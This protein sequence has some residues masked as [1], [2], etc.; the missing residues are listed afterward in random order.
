MGLF[1]FFKKPVK[2]Q[3][4]FF[5]SL[6][7]LAIKGFTKSIFKGQ[8]YFAPTQHII[9][10]F[11]VA[12]SKG[13]TKAQSE[14]YLDL[15]QNFKQWVE[16]IKPLIEDEFLNRDEGFE[17]NDFNKEFT[18]ISLMIPTLD[19]APLKWEMSFSSI[20][21]PNHELTINFIDQT[22]EGISFNG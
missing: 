14:Y 5:G 19:E 16:K 10:L 9:E 7:L 15:Q 13:P 4:D 20:H 8:A 21:E 6:E 1:N 12:D 18:L 11:I 22:P 2:I 3:D 17:I